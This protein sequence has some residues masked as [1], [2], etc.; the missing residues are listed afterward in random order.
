MLQ[1]P[2][3]DHKKDSR[4]SS[5]WIA[6]YPLEHINNPSRTR[7]MI[8]VNAKISTNTWTA[9]SINCPDIT[10]IRI[11]GPWGIL[12]IFNVYND[13]AHSRNTDALNKFLMESR[14]NLDPH[15]PIND[16]WLGDFNRHSPMWDEPRNTQLFTTQA[17]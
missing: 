13:I 5:K 17:L 14:R 16:I 11:S 1:E 12:R 8:L 10:A 2:Y 6:I 7:S 3:F 15:T 9:L 4:V